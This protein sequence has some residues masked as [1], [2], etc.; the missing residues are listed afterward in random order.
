MT[1]PPFRNEEDVK[2]LS[3]LLLHFP[4]LLPT[5]MNPLVREKIAAWIIADK[6]TEKKGISC[7]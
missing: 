1:S 4:E 7:T 5:N 2:K 6:I 3:S